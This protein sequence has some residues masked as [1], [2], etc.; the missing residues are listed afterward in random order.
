MQKQLA[1]CRESSQ[2]FRQL[3]FDIKEQVSSVISGLLLVN[4]IQDYIALND[5]DIVLIINYADEKQ[6]SLILLNAKI[7]AD[8]SLL[9]AVLNLLN[10]TVRATKA[11][12]SNNISIQC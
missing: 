12:D 9:P 6:P 8:A 3:T 2:E 7:A 10:N 1:R 4:N 5:P 11:N